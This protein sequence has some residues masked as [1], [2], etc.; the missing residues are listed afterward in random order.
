VPEDGRDDDEAR[1]ADCDE[2]L[3]RRIS[4]PGV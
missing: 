2:I 3:H 4:R 1:G